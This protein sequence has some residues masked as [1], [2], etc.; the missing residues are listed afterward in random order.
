MSDWVTEWMRVCVCVRRFHFKFKFSRS[1]GKW[2]KIDLCALHFSACMWVVWCV[3]W[4]LLFMSGDCVEWFMCLFLCVFLPNLLRPVTASCHSV[5]CSTLFTF[6]CL[7]A[8]FWLLLLLLSSIT[9]ALSHYA[10]PNALRCAC[11][12]L[13]HCHHNRSGTTFWYG[14]HFNAHQFTFRSCCNFLNHRW[15]PSDFHVRKGRSLYAC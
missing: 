10:I 1:L 6:V 3:R 7:L 12:L 13:K 11:L 15:Q 4:F 9:L 14:N 2:L 5:S 8:A